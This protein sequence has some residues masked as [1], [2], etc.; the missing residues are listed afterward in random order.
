MG[1]TGSQPGEKLGESSENLLRLIDE[2]TDEILQLAH[3]MSA[4][5]ELS[6]VEHQTS[7][8]PNR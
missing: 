4:N 7:G 5:P 6:L 3:W 2:G 8:V 1:K